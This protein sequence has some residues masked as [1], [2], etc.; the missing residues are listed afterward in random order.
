[1]SLQTAL[2]GSQSANPDPFIQP[3]T[4]VMPYEAPFPD[5]DFDVACMKR[6]TT[7]AL[8]S[9]L[10]YPSHLP[11]SVVSSR[12]VPP[13]K[14][15]F[16]FDQEFRHTTNKS[17]NLASSVQ[18]S[19]KNNSKTG[20]NPTANGPASSRHRTNASS[21]THSTRV[22]N[23]STGRG[24][25]GTG[26]SST[27]VSGNREATS[28]RQRRQRTHFTSQQLQE[29]ET[30]FAR[31]RYPDMN[32]REEIAT[33]TELSE[34]RVR[35]WFKNRRAKWR[36]R[37]RHLDVVLRGGLAN[38]FV[39]LFRPGVLT[40][41]ITSLGTSTTENTLYSSNPGL[42]YHCGSMGA[43]LLSAPN[44]YV[45]NSR[46]P[47]L[48]PPPP[49]QPLSRGVSCQRTHGFSPGS[50]NHIQPEN[51]I[52]CPGT[53]F[54][55]GCFSNFCGNRTGITSP[56]GYPGSTVVS[57]EEDKL[58]LSSYFND[59]PGTGI[60]APSQR[61]STMHYS[62]HGTS[63]IDFNAA[64]VAASSM[65]NTYSSVIQNMT[66]PSLFDLSSTHSL[67]PNMS[68]SGALLHEIDH[69]ESVT[70]ELQSSVSN[71]CPQVATNVARSAQNGTGSQTGSFLTGSSSNGFSAAAAAAAVAAWS[72]DRK[73]IFGHSVECDS[74]IAEHPS[75]K[76]GQTRWPL[77][78]QV[79]A[80]CSSDSQ[81]TDHTTI[82]NVLYANPS[83]RCERNTNVAFSQDSCEPNC[84]ISSVKFENDNKFFDFE[85]S[86]PSVTLSS[87]DVKDQRCEAPTIPFGEPLD[88]LQTTTSAATN[89]MSLQSSD[90][91][92][93]NLIVPETV[94]DS[95]ILKEQQTQTSCQSRL[96][97]DN[98][99]LGHSMWST[100]RY[101]PFIPSQNAS[102][103]YT[104]KTAVSA[105]V[106]PVRAIPASNSTDFTSFEQDKAKSN[107]YFGGI[108]TLSPAPCVTALRPGL[109]RPPVSSVRDLTAAMVTATATTT[110]TGRPAF[111]WSNLSDS[112][113]SVHGP[114]NKLAG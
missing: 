67:P 72:A 80:E 93:L 32:L 21:S 81:T 6:L 73:N 92:G 108:S 100:T 53:S 23:A 61:H 106:D 90:R 46:S 2:N 14:S 48:I 39:P 29:L 70:S 78:P 31:N 87:S 84:K 103:P 43:T 98:T 25:D 27:N 49:T 40:N 11:T 26:S 82:M 94:R 59:H 102:S 45:I 3:D 101:L 30:T 20:D 56:S 5:F 96:V 4:F 86:R 7:G 114:I 75:K 110:T 71:A 79:T 91:F 41:S 68:Q 89:F 99:F 54:F 12:S 24:T 22:K 38:P 35:V 28:K 65:F 76:Y 9:G 58:S 107:G 95:D 57:T 64:A 77:H 13:K 83:G 52:F 74:T 63:E 42:A 33:W 18:S 36:K 8:D 104:T 88:I 34:S 62:D 109:Q 69:T 10:S 19:R 17:N 51:T 16:D 66:P 105:A 37:E 85:M 50:Y 15:L 112:S 113:I 44:P 55:S 111:S 97:D 1:M 47:S 60:S